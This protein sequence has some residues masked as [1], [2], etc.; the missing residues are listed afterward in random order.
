M[1]CLVQDHAAGDCSHSKDLQHWQNR[2]RLN[3]ISAG[4]LLKPKDKHSDN[5]IAV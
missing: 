3:K 2:S 5:V 4:V 1:K